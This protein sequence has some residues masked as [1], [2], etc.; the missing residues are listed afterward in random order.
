MKLLKQK[1]SG[2]TFIELLVSAVIV[3]TLSTIALV[4]YQSA[5]QKSRDS[6]RKSDL[7]QVRAALEMYRSQEGVYP[8]GSWSDL[9]SAL[10]D[11]EYIGELPSDPRG[12][13]YYYNSGGN[14]YTMCAYLESEDPG[15]CSASCGSVTCNYGVGNP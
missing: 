15:T 13:S 11:N 9:N 4:Y 10:V 3:I 8:S 2:F 14:T 7:E 12:Y 5:Q 1:K 6:K